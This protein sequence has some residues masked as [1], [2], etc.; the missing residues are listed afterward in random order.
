MIVDD[1]LLPDNFTS[2]DIRKRLVSMLDEQSW[3]TRYFAQTVMRLEIQLCRIRRFKMT[4]IAEPSTET[5]EPL[6]TLIMYYYHFYF[7]IKLLVAIYLN[8]VFDY[9]KYK[10][11]RFNQTAENYKSANLISLEDESV[12]AFRLQLIGD[13]NEAR[14]SFKRI[15]APFINFNF[16]AENILIFLLLIGYSIY[17]QLQYY[18]THKESFDFTL[19]YTVI[20]L[21]SLQDSL[22][23]IIRD[24]VN[25]FIVSSRMHHATV[26]EDRLTNDQQLLE[27]HVDQKENQKSTDIDSAT[28]QV[29]AIQISKNHAFLVRQI[30]SLAMEG[31]LQPFNRRDTKI[32]KIADTFSVLLLLATAAVL[33]WGLMFLTDLPRYIYGADFET[34]PM[35]L[36]F[37]IE[38]YIFV[39]AANISGAFYLLVVMMI[40][41]DQVQ[42]V[43]DLIILIDTCI[44]ENAYI[45]GED[46]KDARIIVAAS[47]A[48]L[49]SGL[50][51]PLVRWSPLRN[52]LLFTQSER[53]TVD[54]SYGEL[55]EQLHSNGSRIRPSIMDAG[56]GYGMTKSYD[57]IDKSVNTTLMHTLLHY[58]IFVKQYT[59]QIDS[60]NIYP[61]LYLFLTTI[62]PVITRLL[63]AYLSGRQKV[64]SIIFCICVISVC[65]IGAAIICRL[66]ARCLDLYR[67]LQSLMAHT[68][69]M[70]QVVR[71]QT[72]REAYDEHLVYML[73][74]E[75]DNPE[76]MLN[77]FALPF[78]ISQSKLTYQ[79]L[80]KH[81]FQLGIIIVSI[82]V[83]DP[84]LPHAADIFGGV[85]RFYSRADAEVN[86]FFYRYRGNVT[87]SG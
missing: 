75:L 10:L 79:S 20:D 28:K 62:M 47:R 66:H 22:D 15:G 86:Q 81:H 9:Y 61:T 1:G 42:L 5:K 29:Q 48:N 23:S 36:I 41:F 31:M 55:A 18:V 46:L 25:S 87:R 19:L 65:D 34:D 12:D 11:D 33:S 67:H 84:T 63:I 52:H 60:I 49:C 54:T 13:Y 76:R 44:S 8:Y 53:M 7:I 39:L 32:K 72:G 16:I 64:V 68:V 43:S 71:M 2:E 4:L 78:L 24:R 80:V 73:R 26:I 35:D 50:D 3:Y 30:R 57:L 45:L 59:S 82:I 51:R 69:E 17:F 6:W 58:K 70:D 27:S 56:E 14:S 77:Q 85:W 40:S 37:G 21:P 83:L 38:L 74:R